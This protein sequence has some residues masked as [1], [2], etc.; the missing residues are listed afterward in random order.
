M[1]K[2]IKAYQRLFFFWGEAHFTNVNYA[3]TIYIGCNLVFVTQIVIFLPKQAKTN[4]TCLHFNGLL[5][6][7]RSIAIPT[8]IEK[9][10]KE[11]H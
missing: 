2:A 7:P 3:S 9:R 6:L 1:Y 5:C 4:T 10:N 8:R 11:L